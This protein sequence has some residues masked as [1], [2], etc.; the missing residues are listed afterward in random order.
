VVLA[1]AVALAAVPVVARADFRVFEAN[2]PEQEGAEALGEEEPESTTTTTTTETT[3]AADGSTTTTTSTTTTV[4]RAAH[5]PRAERRPFLDDHRWLDVTGFV[6]PGYIQR[7]T[8]PAEGIS[9][10][11]TDSTF[12][13]Q[14]ARFGLRAQVF[15]WLRA[16]FEIEMT[17]NTVLQDAYLDFIAGPWLQLRVGQFLVPFLATFRFN[18]LNVSFLDRAVYVPQ[19]PDRG[20]IR[21]L[22]PRDVGFML[23]GRIGNLAPSAS[24][25]V[26]EYMLGGFIGRGPNVALNDD[27]VFLWSARFNLHV[28]GVP[29]GVEQQSDVMRNHIPRVMVGTA[30]YSNCDDRQNWNRGFTVDAEFRYEGFYAE[31]A[32]LWMR[33]GAS[34]TRN[35]PAMA[36]ATPTGQHDAFFLADSTGC[37]GTVRDPADWLPDGTPTTVDFVSRGAH[38]QLQYVLPRFLQ[39]LP[40][41]LMD[42][43]LLARFDWVDANSPYDGGN[44]LF[45]GGPGSPGYLPVGAYNDADNP[46]TRY[47]LTF[48]LNFYPTGQMQYRLGINYQHHLFGEDVVNSMGTYHAITNDIFWFQMTAAI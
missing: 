18:E 46:P 20:Y 15:E 2:A 7:I 19:L 25:P 44:P 26:F 12:W 1:S 23:N 43:E 39:D 5:P 24:D 38:I 30:F 35:R 29:Q 14:R 33:N 28:L 13:L 21:Y 40:F 41:S 8:N 11:A 27:G 10:G 47:R 36:G 37:Q 45:G 32:F 34:G 6:Q 3:T 9:P 17:P 31:A 48:G 22:S 4:T 42:L 16:R